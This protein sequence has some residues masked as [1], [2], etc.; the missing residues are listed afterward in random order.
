VGP[1]IRTE[2]GLLIGTPG[3]AAPEVFLGKPDYRSD[4]FSLGM[5]MATLLSGGPVLG[6]S[7]PRDVFAIYASSAGLPL[8]PSV[9]ET[10]LGS[11][12][13]RALSLKPDQRFAS[14]TEML[15]ALRATG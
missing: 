11:V 3:Y 2:G 6:A 1:G 7:R 9:L 14:A 10:P 4:L 5:T 8:G 12:V 15:D 13:A